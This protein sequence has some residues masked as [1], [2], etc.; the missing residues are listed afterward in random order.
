M[1]ENKQLYWYDF[2]T[3]GTV[4]DAVKKFRQRVHISPTHIGIRPDQFMDGEKWIAKTC[5]KMGLT[6]IVQ[7]TRKPPPQHFFLWYERD[8][9]DVSDS[10]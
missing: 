5:N 3:D 8:E 1:V 7:I 4:R 6:L 10:E 2:W 9:E